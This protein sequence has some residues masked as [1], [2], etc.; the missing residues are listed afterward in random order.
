MLQKGIFKIAKHED[1]KPK[2]N[3][4][5]VELLVK[6]KEYGWDRARAHTGSNTGLMNCIRILY[7]EHKAKIR[8]D[9]VQQNEAKKPYLVKLKGLLAK[10]KSLEKKVN[11]ILDSDIPNEKLKIE[12]INKEISDIKENPETHIGKEVGKAGY[13]IGIII[14]VFLTAYLFVFYSSASFSAFFKTFNLNE[15]GVANSIF[16]AQAISKALQDGI[17]EL[18]L[19]TTIPF[20]FLAL[21]YLIHKFQEGTSWVKHPKIFLLMLVTFVFDGILAFEITNKIQKIQALNNFQEASDLTIKDAFNDVNFWLIIFAGF[22]VYVIWGFV[23]SFVM[24]GHSS[25]NLINKK[26]QKKQEEKKVVE[27][28]IKVFNEEVNKL[29]YLIGENNTHCEK[30]QTILDQTTII[31]PKEIENNIVQFLDGWLEWLASDRRNEV[32]KGEASQKV[33]EFIEI[34]IKSLEINT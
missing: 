11:K 18:L 33:H 8:N 1:E 3:R 32:E 29:N 4:T 22:V 23:F 24:E 21:G 12:E 19:I 5:R 16:D 20:V 14:I 13:I 17:T 28:S 7:E 31:K 9:I 27:D 2:E 34:N 6:I 30:L 15:I 25:I 10:N 26:I